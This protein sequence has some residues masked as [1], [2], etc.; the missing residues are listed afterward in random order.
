MNIRHLKYITTIAEERSISEAARKLFVEQSSLSHCLKKN[1]EEIGMPL[2]L[3]TTPLVPTYA[4]EVYL[5]TARKILALERQLYKQMD[6]IGQNRHGRI[7]IGTLPRIGVITLPYIWPEYQEKYPQIEIRLVEESRNELD[8]MLERGLI[9]LTFTTRLNR[10]PSFSYELVLEEDL[11]M[12]TPNSFFRRN[13][14]HT[15]CEELSSFDSR[16]YQNLPFI[17]L[18]PNHEFRNLVNRF[19]KDYNIDPTIILETDSPTLCTN[20]AM[21]GL[22][23]TIVPSTNVARAASISSSVSIMCLGP[24]YRRS[25]GVAYLKNAYIPKYMQDFI[26]MS[27]TQI[28]SKY[29][30]DFYR[31]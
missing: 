21:Q 22:G 29:P 3:R 12:L 2:F 7:I 14:L 28:A 24:N 23:I 6:D 13:Y 5:E 17:L 27:K 9:D 31:V 16:Q 25:L 19:L 26:A 8:R 1:E 20:L 15:P 18:K 10:N 4:G 11:L 30:P